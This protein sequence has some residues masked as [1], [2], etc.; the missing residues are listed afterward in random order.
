MCAIIGS[1]VG[2][3][4]ILPSVIE[5]EGLKITSM[6]MAPAGALLECDMYGCWNSITFLSLLIYSI[7]GALVGFFIT[8]VF[9]LDYSFDIKSFKFPNIYKFLKLILNL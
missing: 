4:G 9:K 8:L 1:L 7:I 6:V 3:F 5:G 2:F